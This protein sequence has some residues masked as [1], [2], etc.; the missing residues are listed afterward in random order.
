[1]RCLCWLSGHRHWQQQS[2]PSACCWLLSVLLPRRMWLWMLPTTTHTHTPAFASLGMMFHAMLHAEKMQG[3]AYCNCLVAPGWVWMVRHCLLNK[4]APVAFLAAVSAVCC[5]R[6]AYQQ[7][8]VGPYRQQRQGPD[9]HKTKKSLHT[10]VMMHAVVSQC[11]Y[12]TLNAMIHVDSLLQ[13]AD[14]SVLVNPTC[15]LTALAARLRMRVLVIHVGVVQR[16]QTQEQ[17]TDRPVLRCVVV[18]VL[19][20]ARRR[21]CC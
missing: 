3:C 16:C 12:M 1:M 17:P 15:G 5:C 4:H 20:L 11:V 7:P 9:G 21:V 2:Q 14:C 13:S 10:C 8:L 19:P 18:V 6:Q